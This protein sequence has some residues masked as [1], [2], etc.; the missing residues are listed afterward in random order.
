MVR[1][2]VIPQRKSGKL[3][4][5]CKVSGSVSATGTVLLPDHPAIVYFARWT[6]DCPGSLIAFP[7]FP[8]IRVYPV[9]LWLKGSTGG[10]LDQSHLTTT[11]PFS[12]LQI[13]TASPPRSS[14]FSHVY[15]P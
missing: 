5:E 6:P 11:S 4:I 14:R 1:R 3:K 10:F 13:H 15:Q 9:H 2:R 8:G 7:I 12:S